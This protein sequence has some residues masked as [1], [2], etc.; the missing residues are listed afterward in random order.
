MKLSEAI[1]EGCKHTRKCVHGYIECDK[2]GNIIAACTIGAAYLG[3]TGYRIRIETHHL[4]SNALQK[5]FPVLFIFPDDLREETL[6][7]IISRMNDREDYT[8]EQIAQWLIDERN[9]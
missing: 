7:K 1:I 4:I 2:N 8:R 9:L 5:L 6:F 3:A